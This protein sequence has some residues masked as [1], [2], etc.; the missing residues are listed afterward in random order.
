MVD[1]VL[2]DSNIPRRKGEL[3]KALWSGHAGEST[4][5]AT[6]MLAESPR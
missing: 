1:V 2:L 3:V 6:K 4:Y 5:L